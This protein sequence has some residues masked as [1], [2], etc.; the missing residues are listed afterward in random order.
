MGFN[1]F[2]SKYYFRIYITYNTQKILVNYGKHFFGASKST[3]EIK[4][5]GKSN[6][7]STNKE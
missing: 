2:T 6:K 4:L 5:F 3:Y 7:W 1:I